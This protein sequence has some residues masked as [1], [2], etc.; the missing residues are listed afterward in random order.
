LIH[1]VLNP[2]VWDSRE[3]YLRVEGIVIDETDGDDEDEEDNEDDSEEEDTEKDGKDLGKDEA[4]SNVAYNSLLSA[5]KKDKNPPPPHSKEE[6]KLKAS[7]K[8][9]VDKQHKIEEDI[10]FTESSVSSLA[11][12][13]GGGEDGLWMTVRLWQSFIE[14]RLVG[15]QNEMQ[16]EFQ[17][18]LI[19][20]L[21]KE[22]GL[23]ENEL[24]S[25][26]GFDDLSTALQQEVKD[27]QKRM[28]LE[29]KPLV[30]ES[31]LTIQ[32]VLEC[33]DHTQRV[34][35]L[36]YFVDAEKRRLDAKATLR[37]MF[38]GSP[39]AVSEDFVEKGEEERVV[40]KETVKKKKEEEEE[41][42]RN[43]SSR[44]M[45]EMMNLDVDVGD[46]KGSLFT[47]EPDAFQ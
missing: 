25:A 6:V 4:I 1:R 3:T 37:D 30:L 5:L 29:L 40:K 9:L 2:E 39:D 8:A 42:E 22:K 38:S 35:L 31:T 21:K 46:A 14:Q 20:F 7:F 13:P 18:K 28:Q 27:L 15:R 16:M 33:D 10:R 11:V 44:N 43:D 36:R 45:V 19:T 23:E 17:K 47:D 32:K 24:P 26:I 41:E 34:N 12:A